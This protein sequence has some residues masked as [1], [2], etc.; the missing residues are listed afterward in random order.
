[1]ANSLEG[2]APAARV[3]ATRHGVVFVLKGRRREGSGCGEDHTLHVWHHR[4]GCDTLATPNGGRKRGGRKY[5]TYRTT[6]K[7][8]SGNDGRC[9]AELVRRVGSQSVTPVTLRTQHPIRCSETMKLSKYRSSGWAAP[10][11]Q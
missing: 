8:D 3:G 5:E 4:V 11:F 1:M 2:A 10:A 7:R 6:Y 9:R